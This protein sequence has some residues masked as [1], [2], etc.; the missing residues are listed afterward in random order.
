[1]SLSEIAL[2]AGGLAVGAGV[3]SIAVYL[4]MR[5]R[6]RP[7]GS[8]QTDLSTPPS[9]SVEV[10]IND[11]P[12]KQSVVPKDQLEKSRRELRTLLLEKELVSAA[13]TRL[14]EAEIAKEITKEERESLGGRYKSE[15]KTLDERISKIDA[16][17]QIGDLETLRDQLTRLVEQKMQAIDKRIESTKLLAG[18]LLA[19]L[20][21]QPEPMKQKHELDQKP[22]VPDISDLLKEP[23]PNPLPLPIAQMEQRLPEATNSSSTVLIQ[24]EIKRRIGS[25]DAQAEELQKELLEALDRLSKLDVET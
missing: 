11:T 3:G 10:T 6:N 2:A 18:P 21:R 17:I 7:G 22:K 4:S 12:R 5:G 1:M 16:F 8:T 25:T 19:E 9:Q 23:S 15:L 24:P 14:Y 13:L 20:T